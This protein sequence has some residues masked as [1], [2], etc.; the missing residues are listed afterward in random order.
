MSNA[1]CL[2]DIK[3]IGAACG[4]GTPLA[5]PYKFGLARP[6]FTFADWSALATLATVKTA[7]ANKDMLI[8]EGVV[9]GEDQKV[10]DNVEDT[11]HERIHVNYG[12]RG[13][14]LTLNLTKDQHKIFFEE[15]NN[16]KWDLWAMDRNNNWH[17]IVNDDDTIQGVPLDY[18]QVK[19][20]MDAAQGQAVKT[21]V[22]YQHE[23]AT[24][25]DTHGGWLNPSYNLSKV[26]PITNVTLSN[27]STVAADA[28]TVQVDYTE[29]QTAKADGTTASVAISGLD[30]NDFEL[31]NTDGTTNTISTV[32][33]SSTTPGLYTITGTTFTAGS[34]QVIPNTANADLYESAVQALT[35]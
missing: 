8:V 32:V 26:K 17:V 10:E 33:E 22:E 18:F 19:Q 30:E 25:W 4:K 15:Y 11:G 2:N 27:A 23:D 28:F 14:M 21:P 7:I 6:G 35:A 12:V 9:G 3:G 5:E 24:L 29:T 20:S 13:K 16:K 1:V 31:L 34:V